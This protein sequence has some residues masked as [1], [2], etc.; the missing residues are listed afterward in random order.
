MAEIENIPGADI[1]IRHMVFVKNK[2]HKEIS[3]QLR[4]LSRNNSEIE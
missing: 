4:M 3:E 1:F 2:T